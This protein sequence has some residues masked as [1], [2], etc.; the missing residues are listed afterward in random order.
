MVEQEA[1]NFEVTG[2][3]PVRGA[4][5]NNVQKNPFYQMDFFNSYPS[6]P[7]VSATVFATPLHYAIILNMTIKRSPKNYAFIDGNNTRRRY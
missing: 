5:Q 6:F 1:V 7:F 4:N 2:S 3:S